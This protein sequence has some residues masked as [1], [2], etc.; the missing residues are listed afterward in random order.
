M[1]TSPPVFVRLRPLTRVVLLCLAGVLPARAAAAEGRT[2]EQIYRQQ[3]A[4]CPGVAGE[5]SAEA[6]P[7]RLEGTRSGDQL[8]R[9]IARTMPKDADEKCSGADARKVASYIYEAF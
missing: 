2:G 5:G 6:S 9:L 8:A 4:S 1:K 3:C 7:P